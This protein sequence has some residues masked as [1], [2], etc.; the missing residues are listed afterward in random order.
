MNAIILI[1]GLVTLTLSGAALLLAT[2]LRNGDRPGDARVT[3]V[4]VTG[5]PDEGTAE[6]T[7]AIA[8]PGGTPVL[9]GL[10]PSR[11]SWPARGTRTTVPFRTTRR[12][13]R[14]DRQTAVGAVPP[15]SVTRLSVLIP[16]R[17][18]GLAAV[19]G[20]PDGR[21]RVI[22]MPVNHRRLTVRQ[23]GAHGGPGTTAPPPPFPFLWPR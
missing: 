15:R 13:Y 2:G 22:S 14:A 10:S 3:A 21:L 7:V 16:I 6:V 23:D 11:A 5:Y 1:A 12:R 8:N 20:Q 9:I 18:C 19:I 17:R 4:T